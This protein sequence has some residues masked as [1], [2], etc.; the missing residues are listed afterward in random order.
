MIPTKSHFLILFSVV[1]IV[2]GI[3][4][5]F[6]PIKISTL[7][8]CTLNH[9]DKK[10]LCP[11][12]TV[13]GRIKGKCALAPCPGIYEPGVWRTFTKPSTIVLKNYLT[14]L[15]YSVTQEEGTETP[16]QNEFLDNEEEGI[17]VDIVSGEP[18]F[19]SQDKYDS[20]TGCP[21][22][23]Q[24]LIAENIVEK[25]KGSSFVDIHSKHGDSHLGKLFTDGPAPSGLRYCV[26]SASLRF[27]PK[28]K[29]VEQG[30]SEFVS[31]FEKK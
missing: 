5:R 22:F 29:L 3:G 24:P 11:D 6:F 20:L 13:V 18:L 7:P 2:I 15:Q 9:S 10:V 4:Y 26:N 21:S 30:Y 1:G 14:P 17:Y 12:G 28:E 25:E 27:V 19:S 31:L 8:A 23:T 16:Y